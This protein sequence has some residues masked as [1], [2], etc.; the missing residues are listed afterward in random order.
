MAELLMISIGPVQGF[1]AQARR[2]RDLWFGSHL[3]SE[4][5][6]AAARETVAHNG[7]L[8]FPALT[9]PEEL[10][11]CDGMLRPSGK[12]PVSVA[13]KLLVYVELGPASLLYERAGQAAL[14]R[15]WELAK[16]ARDRAEGLI[17]FGTEAVWREQIDT[18]LELAGAW[19]EIQPAAE[20]AYCIARRELERAIGARKTLR[21]FS[22]WQHSRPGAPKSSLDGDRE[23]ILRSSS[24]RDKSAQARY[25]IADGEELDAIGVTKRAGGKPDQFLPV[26]NVAAA[27]W[28]KAAVALCPEDLAEA[29]R[30]ACCCHVGRV[31]SPLRAAKDWP[32][33]ATVLYPWRLR[34][35]LEEADP[36]AEGPLLRERERRLGGALRPIVRRIGE[37]H[38]YVACLVADGDRMGETIDSLPGR[39]RHRELS[40]ELG[41]FAQQVGDVVDLDLGLPIYAGGD[42]VL[43]LLSVEKALACAERLRK[44]FA[45]RLGGFSRQDGS[46]PTLSVG[47]AVLHNLEA[48]GELLGLARQAE[49]LAKRP[50]PGQPG[51]DAL[52]VIVRKRSGEEIRWRCGWKERPLERIERAQQILCSG[53]VSTSALYEVRSSLK[54]LVPSRAALQPELLRALRGQVLY[55]LAHKGVEHPLE[56][57]PP[58]SQPT[59]RLAERLDEWVCEL[60]LARAMVEAQPRGSREVAWTENEPVVAG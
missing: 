40:V 24:E 14:E 10:E 32:F 8:V 36:A 41:R 47:I 35:A 23:T 56:V 7:E 12:R 33:D 50:S 15:F 58:L 60:L 55:T 6:R 25:R 17:A 26:A 39:C 2:T 38:P 9:D 52:A 44:C 59:E 28:I 51:R 20:D 43:C 31:E 4:L 34:S 5:A 54:R 37:P 22:Q 13:N 29:R 46:A 18:F 49:L 30:V 48:M 45:G 3:L 11:P 27:P 1:I 57:C 19:T 21:D 42:D 53:L 16:L